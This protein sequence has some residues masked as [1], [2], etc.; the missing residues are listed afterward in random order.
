MRI[1]RQNNL[2]IASAEDQGLFYKPHNRYVVSNYELDELMAKSPR[3]VFNWSNFTPYE[4]RYAGQDL[5]GKRVC[6]YR[7]SAWG[8]QLI[9]SALPH[10][11]KT[12]YPDAILNMYCHPKVLSLWRGNQFVMGS[13][14]PLP[15]PFD[16]V[17][18]GYDYHIFLEGMLE[19]DSEIDQE[20]C[21]DSMFSFCGFKP[22]DVPAVYKRPCVFPMPDDYRLF[23]QLKLPSKYILYH[24]SPN[25]MN[26]CYPVELGAKLC[27]LV[28]EYFGVPV[29]VVGS[30][31]KKYKSNSLWFDGILGVTNLV[32][33]TAS[34]RDLIPIVENASLLICPDSAV[35]HLASCF[36][37]VPVVSLWGLFSPNDRIKYYPNSYPLF[38]KHVCSVAPCHCHDFELP[39]PDCR[40]AKGVVEGTEIKWCP[41]M[42]SYKPEDIVNFI[43]QKGLLKQ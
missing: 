16:A 8:D 11:L 42:G 41:V 10:Y 37:H 6:I 23:P 43:E 1:V 39:L 36:P 33:K 30:F 25:N 21:Y 4:K 12:L 35:M 19:S 3:T 20:N 5:N 40:N 26:R 9:V 17:K 13:A 18:Y 24:A 15:I 38:N 32:D 7:H 28:Y 29:V 34:F 2:L 31:E 14:I 22:E 27:K